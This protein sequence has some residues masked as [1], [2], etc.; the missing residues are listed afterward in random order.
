MAK[1]PW[2]QW[3]PLDYLA[4]TRH[5]SKA[6]RSV[7]TDIL[8][9]AWLSKPRGVYAR[10]K[11]AMRREL[12]ISVD[13]WDSII[14]ELETVADVTVGPDTVTVLSRR[15]VRE[16]SAREYERNKKRRQRSPADVPELS[17]DRPREKLEVRS[18]K[19]LNTPNPASGDLCFYCSAPTSKAGGLRPDPAPPEEVPA[20]VWTCM[21]CAMI[22]KGRYFVRVED[23]RAYIQRILWTT[24]RGRWV[25]HRKYAFGGKSPFD[26]PKPP[27]EPPID[28]KD[29][30]SPD[31]I[32]EILAANGFGP[33]RA[34]TKAQ[35]RNE[36]ETGEGA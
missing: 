3:F 35:D 21:T 18:Q 36:V 29:L 23:C 9:L 2:M 6:C 19:S 24:N 17:P 27:P 7:W 8:N 31:E 10:T 22:K 16:E 33:K 25:Q 5:L 14:A 28:P 30:A 20:P 1:L 15:I 12:D 26:R 32:R 11:A 4:D 34:H 13:E